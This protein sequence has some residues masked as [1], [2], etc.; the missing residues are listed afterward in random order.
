M[1]AGPDLVGPLTTDN[2]GLPETA[3]APPTVA[4]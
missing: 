3:F 1:R 4:S 2:W